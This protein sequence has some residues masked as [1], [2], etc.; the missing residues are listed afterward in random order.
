M[1]LTHLWGKQRTYRFPFGG[2]FFS[3]DF[4]NFNKLIPRLLNLFFEPGGQI[5][6]Q[7]SESRGQGR[8]LSA[9]ESRKDRRNIALLLVFASDW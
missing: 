2:D 8:A 3:P 5:T 4:K 1:W 6:L 9:G 7:I